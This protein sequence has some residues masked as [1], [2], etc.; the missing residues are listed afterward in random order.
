M[1]L[2]KYTDNYL[3][4]FSEANFCITEEAFLRFL[5]IKKWLDTLIHKRNDNKCCWKIRKHF[6]SD[7]K[8]ELEEIILYGRFLWS[9]I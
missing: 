5:M 3:L 9:W 6:W 4:E 1:I 2:S 8:Q 7:E